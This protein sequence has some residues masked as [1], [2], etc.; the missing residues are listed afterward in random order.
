MF[1]FITF[2]AKVHSGISMADESCPRQDVSRL[3]K[4]GGFSKL[5]FL[6][7]FAAVESKW[8]PVVRPEDE[9]EM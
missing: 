8:V 4:G 9:S 7:N 2:S 5:R 6:V 1:V 3:G